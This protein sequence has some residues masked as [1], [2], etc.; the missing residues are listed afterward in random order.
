MIPKKIH[1]IWITKNESSLIDLDKSIR[2]N[3][4]YHIENN[5]R[6][7]SRIYQNEDIKKYILDNYNHR[8]LELYNI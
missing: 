3:I 7:D 4:D 1:Q 5:S 2:S 6:M 8:V